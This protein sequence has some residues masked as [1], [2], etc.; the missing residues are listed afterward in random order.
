MKIVKKLHQFFKQYVNCGGLKTHL[1]FFVR[2]EIIQTLIKNN[3][4]HHTRRNRN[5]TKFEVKI[6]NKVRLAYLQ[7]LGCFSNTS[8]MKVVVQTEL[9]TSQTVEE[10]TNDANIFFLVVIRNRGCVDTHELVLLLNYRTFFFLSYISYDNFII[11]CFL[12]LRLRQ[13]CTYSFK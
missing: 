7:P 9:K 8:V 13:C 6:L 12:F 3:T 5:N 10:S 4:N 2:S 1:N 11:P